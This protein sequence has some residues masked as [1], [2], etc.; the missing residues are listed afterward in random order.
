MVVVRVEIVI[1]IYL[2]AMF[3]LASITRIQIGSY[4]RILYRWVIEG[5]CFDSVKLIWMY[6]YLLLCSFI[7]THYYYHFFLL[8]LFFLFYFVHYSSKYCGDGAPY[9][10][11]YVVVFGFFCFFYFYDE[12]TAF[13]WLFYQQQPV[14]QW[15]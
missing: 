9:F 4:T 11:L 1:E 6:W 10:H 3:S 8:L 5:G 14:F 13:Y 12:F 2:D 7:I 15:A